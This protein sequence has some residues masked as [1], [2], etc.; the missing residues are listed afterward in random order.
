PP[1][2]AGNPWSRSGQKMW[3]LIFRPDSWGANNPDKKRQNSKLP[4]GDRRDVKCPKAG[5]RT[6]RRLTF[7]LPNLHTV[8]IFFL[9]R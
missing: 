5:I 1:S 2:I 8:L 3:I 7:L 9:R 4:R 6:Y